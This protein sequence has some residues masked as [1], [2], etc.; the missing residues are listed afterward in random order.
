MKIAGDPNPENAQIISRLFIRNDSIP[1]E[2]KNSE[3]IEEVLVRSQKFLHQLLHTYPSSANILIVGSP[4][5][6]SFIIA[7]LK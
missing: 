6:N 3:T 7:Q 1:S 5:I 2:K 4:I